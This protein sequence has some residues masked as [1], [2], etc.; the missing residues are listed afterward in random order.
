MCAFAAAWTC[1]ALDINK[2]LTNYVLIASF[3]AL[4]SKTTDGVNLPLQSTLKVRLHL[5]QTEVQRAHSQNRPCTSN[6][7][8]KCCE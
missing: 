1:K 5:L 6:T 8:V 7:Y 4:L 3:F 2:N